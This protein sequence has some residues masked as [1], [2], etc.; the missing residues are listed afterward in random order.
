MRIQSVIAEL[1]A[2]QAAGVIEAYAIGGAVAATFYLEPVSTVD[3]D[4]FVAMHVSPGKLILDPQPIFQFLS[5]RGHEMKGEYMLIGTWPVQFLAGTGALTDEAVLSAQTWD[6][7][8][9]P[10]RV[11]TANNT[12]S[13]VKENGDQRCAEAVVGADQKLIYRESE[14]R[15]PILDRN[16]VYI[17]SSGKNNAF[18][19]LRFV[20]C[21]G[22]PP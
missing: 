12:P 9:T 8:G 18:L 5:G 2:L 13:C 20:D 15:F 17:Y 22:T 10:A 7:E 1:N 11:F 21:L 6:V 16:C 3:V 14:R 19:A 4:V